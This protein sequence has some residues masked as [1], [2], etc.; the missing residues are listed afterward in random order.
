MADWNIKNL[1]WLGDPSCA[2]D[3]LDHLFANRE[4]FDGKTIY[5][6]NGAKFDMHILFKYALKDH[7][8]WR[9]RSTSF[10]V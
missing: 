1:Q 6:H 5:A 3:F 9:I 2:K 7:K 10:V 8:D 4:L